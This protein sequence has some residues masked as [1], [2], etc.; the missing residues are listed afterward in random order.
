MKIELTNGKYFREGK[1]YSERFACEMT[2]SSDLDNPVSDE[3]IE[4][5]ADAAECF[6]DEMMNTIN[7]AA[8][9]YALTL[10][11]EIREETGEDFSF[12]D[13]DLPEITE[14][15][16]ASEMPEYFR[17]NEL[18]ADKPE[19][20]NQLYFRLSGGCDWEIEHGLEAA[21]CDG[22]LIYLGSFEQATPH[23][24]DYFTSGKGREWN[25]AIE[26]E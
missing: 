3:Y 4:R 17:F 23:R 18:S 20:E 13:E 21:F 24:V 5:C 26:G 8:K 12:E 9:R 15:T 7:E 10:I 14:D 16:P 22:K 11:E 2:A 6:S 25:Y 1:Y 19:H